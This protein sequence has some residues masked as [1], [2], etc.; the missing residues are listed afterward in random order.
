MEGREIKIQF[1][2]VGWYYNQDTILEGLKELNEQN[3]NIDIFY[4]CHKEPTQYIKDNFNWKLF[5]NVGEEQVAY[6]QAIE[7]L[8]IDDDTYCFLLNDD[9]IIKDWNFIN[10]CIGKLQEGFKLVGNGWNPGFKSYDPFITIPIG[11]TPEFDGLQGKDYVKDENKHLFDRKLEMNMARGSFW[12]MQ[13]K[14]IE[15][16]GGFEPRK[17]AWVPVNFND[18]GKPY[19]RG[20]EDQANTKTGGMAL[21]GNL[22]ANLCVYKI[23]RIFG[24]DSVTWLSDQ[25]RDSEYIYELERGID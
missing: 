24:K 14:T 22:F 25:Y 7:H 3:D 15:A 4:S 12:C 23:N 1:I 13:Y 2:V 6:Q 21:F 16:I 11:I 19:Y 20:C 10:V 9:L 18:N 8:D 5:A 17:E